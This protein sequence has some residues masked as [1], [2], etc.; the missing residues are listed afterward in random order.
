MESSLKNR[1]ENSVKSKG[2]FST[3][4]NSYSQYRNAVHSNNAGDQLNEKKKVEASKQTQMNEWKINNASRTI[5]EDYYNE[6]ARGED[7]TVSKVHRDDSFS[8]QS[9]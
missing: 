6:D 3:A 1:G 7:L 8:Q 9:D 2:N 5:D 4:F